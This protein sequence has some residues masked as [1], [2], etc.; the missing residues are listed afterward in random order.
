MAQYGVKEVM[1]FTI[2]NYVPNLLERE[3]ILTVD[4]AKMTD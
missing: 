3:P 1:D 4:Y 2:A